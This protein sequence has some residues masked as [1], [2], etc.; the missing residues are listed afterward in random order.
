MEGQ[1]I[2]VNSK[3]VAFLLTL[4]EYFTFIQVRET[5]SGISI[6]S[7]RHQPFSQPFN[8]DKRTREKIK[9]IENSERGRT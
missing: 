1:V 5:E 6:S 7:I 8:C 4:E 2:V 3:G 9:E